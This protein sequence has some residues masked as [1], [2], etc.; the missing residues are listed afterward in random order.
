MRGVCPKSHKRLW[1]PVFP[2]P[3]LSF[4]PPMMDEDMS[5]NALIFCLTNAYKKWYSSRQYR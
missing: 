4:F 3:D 5:L 1:A 2:A